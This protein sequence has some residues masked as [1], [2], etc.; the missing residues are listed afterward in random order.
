MTGT[1]TMTQPQTPAQEWFFNNRENYQLGIHVIGVETDSPIYVGG[2][3][4]RPQGHLPF[5]NQWNGCGS[6]DLDECCRKMR[7]YFEGDHQ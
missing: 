2:E 7:D 1:L 5:F 4:F 6:R 3:Y